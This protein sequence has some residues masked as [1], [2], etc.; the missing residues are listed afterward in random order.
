[1]RIVIMTNLL[2]CV[3]CGPSLDPVAAQYAAQGS[4]CVARA[5]SREESRQCREEAK[6]KLGV[7]GGMR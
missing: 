2:L 5:A 4:E 7:D 3:C 1:M 6:R